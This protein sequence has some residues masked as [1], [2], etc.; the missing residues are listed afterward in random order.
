M[1]NAI[2]IRPSAAVAETGRT[3]TA[4]RHADELLEFI[5]RPADSFRG[6]LDART[7]ALVVD[8]VSAVLATPLAEE[9]EARAE[10]MTMIGSYPRQPDNPEI[11]CGALAKE[12]SRWPAD[13]IREARRTIVRTIRFLPSVAELA[14]ACESIQARRRMLLIAAERMERERQRREEEEQRRAR[15]EAQQQARRRAITGEA[16]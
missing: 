15:V 11:Y 10:I 3:P 4:D 6:L 9:R 5:S 7:L 16:Q 12:A 2:A 14:G 1:S 13:V 8:E